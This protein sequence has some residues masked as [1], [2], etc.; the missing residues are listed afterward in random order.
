MELREI[1]NPARRLLCQT[2]G[3]SE[4]GARGGSPRG[5]P[6]AIAERE[7]GRSRLIATTVTA[8]VASLAVTGVVAVVLPGPASSAT[9][10]TPGTS[11]GTS[12]QENQGTSGGLT[13]PVY[14]PAPASG[15]GGAVSTSGGSHS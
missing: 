1:V 4:V 11:T 7:R 15:G 14:A 6:E 13:P 2:N 9:V 8:G 12:G 3:M 5:V 10:T